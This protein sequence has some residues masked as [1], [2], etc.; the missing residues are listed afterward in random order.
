MNDAAA[1]FAVF[2]HPIAH[3][4]SPWIHGEFAHQSG[5]VLEYEAIDAT[6]AQFAER[7]A[8]FAARGGRGANVTLPLKEL[9]LDLCAQV[10]EAARIAG[11]VNMLTRVDGGWHGENTDGVGFMRDLA[12]RHRVHVRGRRALLL[13]AGG[14]AHGVAPALHAAGVSELIISNRTAERADRLADA[15]G[16]P[17]GVHTRYWDKLGEA[18]NFD[19]IVNATSAGRDE[20]PGFALPYSLVG[21]R[22]LCYDLNYGEVAHGFLAWAR[23]AGAQHAFDGLGMLVEQAAEAFERWHGKRPDTDAV[24]DSLRSR[25]P[26]LATGD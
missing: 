26:A 14:A 21:A 24:H 16:D 18:G 25:A 20:T 7:L 13:G 12:D 17:A 15:I 23:S 22:C 5:I 4:Q 1:L 3:S 19:L 11:A 6:P 2:G 10:S 9:A 8:A